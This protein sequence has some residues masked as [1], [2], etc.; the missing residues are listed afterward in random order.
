MTGTSFRVARRSTQ[1]GPPMA[2]FNGVINL[3]VRDSVQDWGP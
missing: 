1:E 2:A 3:D